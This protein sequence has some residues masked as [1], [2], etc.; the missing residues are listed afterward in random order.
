MDSKK[1][2]SQQKEAGTK[3]HILHNCSYL[4]MKF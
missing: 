4:N 2:A 3:Q 1:H